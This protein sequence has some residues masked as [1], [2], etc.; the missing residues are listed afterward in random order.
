[1]PLS[2]AQRLRKLRIEHNL[3]QA[4]VGEYVGVAQPVVW[5]WEN[6][7]VKR[8]TDENAE[9]LSKLY[10]VSKA[11]IVSGV[12]VGDLPQ[13]VEEW[14]H[15]PLNRKKVLEFYRN[16]KMEEQKEKLSKLK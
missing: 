10:G 4:E 16:Y 15:N 5:R 13:E 6:E 7:K 9:K 12:N 2:L 3:T 1:M 14:L 8:I 11:Y